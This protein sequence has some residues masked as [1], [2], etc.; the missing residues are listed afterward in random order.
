MYIAILSDIHANFQAL[1]AVLED[2][3]HFSIDKIISLG[4]NI[5]YGPQPEE[6]IRTLQQQNIISIMG[7]HE[8]ALANASYYNCLN[9][10]PQRS[11][12]IQRQ[13]M[14]KESLEYC[15][16]LPKLK[17]LDDV[18][19][20]HGCPPRSMTS[21]LL[22]PT[23]LK[24]ER[25]FAG[26]PEKICF[27]GHIHTFDRYI[28]EQNQCRHEEGEIGTFHYSSSNRYLFNPGSVG[29]P[30]DGLNRMAKYALFDPSAQTLE[31]RQT[32]YDAKL[33]KQ[34]LQEYNFPEMNGYRL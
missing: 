22:Q 23:M 34:L 1:T 25:I 13:Q 14:S 29:Q 16:S 17:I 19:F 30:R 11:L 4:D 26:Y 31:L 24:M 33:T 21:Y 32:A 20:I 10:D 8:Y 3:E 2:L 7:N 5:G 12:D 28:L 6:V 9:P 27:F 15:I 18:R